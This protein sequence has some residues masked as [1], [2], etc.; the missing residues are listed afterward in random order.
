VA[1]SSNSSAAQVQGV[2]RLVAALDLPVPTSPV[3]FMLLAR[4]NF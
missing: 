2:K 3:P 1:E 4:S